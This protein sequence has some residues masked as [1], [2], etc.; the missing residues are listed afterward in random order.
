M[1]WLCHCRHGASNRK[2]VRNY[3]MTT[4]EDNDNNDDGVY[5][6]VNDDVGI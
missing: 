3:G 5:N 2:F 6:D 4:D 1:N